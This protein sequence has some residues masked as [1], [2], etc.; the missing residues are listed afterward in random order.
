ML[1]Q[2]FSIQVTP[3]LQLM[4]RILLSMNTQLQLCTNHRDL[5]RLSTQEPD[6]PGNS[7]HICPTRY[8]LI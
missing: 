6:N 5:T 4:K 2:V 8:I 1:A 3:G 7:E